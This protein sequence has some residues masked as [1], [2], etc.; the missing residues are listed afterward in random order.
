MKSYVTKLKSFKFISH[1]LAFVDLSPTPGTNCTT[2][3]LLTRQQ[4]QS[5]ASQIMHT[6]LI[7]TAANAAA[8]LDNTEAGQVAD[9]CN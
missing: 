6:N 2:K 7:A 4:G 1:L 9:N 5:I 8:A 3:P